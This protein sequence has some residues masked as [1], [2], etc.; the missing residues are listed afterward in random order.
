[1]HG[2]L[3]ASPM[4]PALYFSGRIDQAE[5]TF[6]RAVGL[7]DTIGDRRHCIY[8]L[9][10][11]A[12]IAAESGR[13]PQKPSTSFAQ[14]TGIGADSVDSGPFINAIVPLAAAIVLDVRGDRVAAAAATS[15]WRLSLRAQRRGTARSRQDAAVQSQ[16]P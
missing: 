9:G 2:R 5:E 13:F 12:L 16:G 7:A 8:A 1:M 14:A 6:R 3:P 4:A 10:Y 15:T 11:I